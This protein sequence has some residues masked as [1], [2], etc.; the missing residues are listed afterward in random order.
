MRDTATAPSSNER[1]L[2]QGK[3]LSESLCALPVKALLCTEVVL[4]Q[5]RPTDQ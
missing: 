4:V 2:L 5:Y 1:G 3:K